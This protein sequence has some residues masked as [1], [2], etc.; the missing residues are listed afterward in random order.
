MVQ[1]IRAKRYGLDM[2]LFGVL[3]IPGMGKGMKSV[4][5]VDGPGVQTP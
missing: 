5:C 1:A 4:S 3:A 2:I